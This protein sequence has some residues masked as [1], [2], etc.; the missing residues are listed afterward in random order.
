MEPVLVLVHSP[1][2]GP[3]TWSLVAG[4]LRA[5]GHDAVL[6]E[7]SDAGPPGEPFWRRHAASAARALAGVPAERELVLVG[8]SGA[9]PLLPAIRQAAGREM[10]GYLFVDAGLPED[11]VSRLEQIARE[12]PEMG[13]QFRRLLES[14]GRFPTWGDGDLREILPDPDLRRGVIA[15]LH[16]RS[17]DFF[18]EPLSAFPGWPDAPCGY[19]RFSSPYDVPAAGARARGWPAL[20]M[21]AGHFHMLVDPTAVAAAMLDLAAA[22]RAR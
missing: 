22:L 20:S 15:E 9:G 18:T 14:G 6:P 5:R 10:A 19:L 17:L 1:L 21:D 11:G 3:L 16:P 7:L 12:S 8:H 4:E 13:E 2:V